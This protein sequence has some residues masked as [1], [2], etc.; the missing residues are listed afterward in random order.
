MKLLGYQ[1]DDVRL[2]VRQ[3]VDENS[4]VEDELLE[5]PPEDA[6]RYVL[7]WIEGTSER[8]ALIDLV[9]RIDEILHPN[10]WRR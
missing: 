5:E 2:A 6:V 1:I 3:Y 9:E 7:K 8:Q 10:Q 4:L